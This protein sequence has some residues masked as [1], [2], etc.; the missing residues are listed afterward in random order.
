MLKGVATSSELI[1]GLVYFGFIGLVVGAIFG[2]VVNMKHT[3]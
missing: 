1:G 3:A 2:L